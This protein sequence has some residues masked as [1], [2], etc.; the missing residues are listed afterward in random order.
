MAA[1]L[2]FACAK[3]ISVSRMKDFKNKLNH[4]YPTFSCFGTYS[5]NPTKI[6][7]GY[8]VDLKFYIIYENLIYKM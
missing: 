1:G 7:T 4:Q 3:R 5:L 8:Q 6:R 2:Q